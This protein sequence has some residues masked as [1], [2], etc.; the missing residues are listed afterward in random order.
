MKIN[1]PVIYCRNCFKPTM[2]SFNILKRVMGMSKQSYHKKDDRLL[3]TTAQ[4]KQRGP[5][6]LSSNSVAQKR[7]TVIQI[8]IIFR[9]FITAD[10]SFTLQFLV[11]GPGVGTTDGNSL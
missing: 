4:W 6:S 2:D 3:S 10:Y 11:D 1:L 5:Y 9:K 8:R 7:R